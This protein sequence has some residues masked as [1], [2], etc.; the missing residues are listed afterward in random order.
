MQ[1]LSGWKEIAVYLRCG[2][3]TVQ[4]WERREGLPV[5]RHP[6]DK[7]GTV[8]AFQSEIDIWLEQRNLTIADRIRG[9]LG[10]QLQELRGLTKQAQP[11]TLRSHE[12]KNGVA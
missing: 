4:R 3:R 9:E 2:V 1:A 8:Y 10:Q 5:H 7:R 12:R 6:H 11:T